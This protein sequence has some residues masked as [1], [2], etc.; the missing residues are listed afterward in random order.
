MNSVTPAERVSPPVVIANRHKKRTA[1][2]RQAISQAMLYLVLLLGSVVMLLPLIWM[3]S[4][5][6]KPIE[7][8][9][10]PEFRL[11]PSRFLLLQNLAAA[12]QRISMIKF[13]TN[14]AIVS[15]SVTVGRVFLCA[16]AGYSFAKFTY[17][18]RHLLFTLVLATMMIPFYVVVI[19]L[20]IVVYKLGWLNNLIALIVPGLVTAFGIFLM[21]QFILGIPS[22]LIDAA[23]IDGASEL[24]I[25]L[26]IVLPL[27]KPA[28]STLAI[29]TFMSTW[30]AYVWP[31]LVITKEDLMT[32][33]LGLA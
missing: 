32:I 6:S 5:A 15:A 18:G 3:L 16:L 7:E 29:F 28:L 2:M 20:Y 23:R 33:P 17:P 12:F 10:I 19:P 11:I 30:D 27:T 13:F 22:E 26:T 31:M 9:I 1:M 14:S 25:F 8:T 24:R 4:T 21:R